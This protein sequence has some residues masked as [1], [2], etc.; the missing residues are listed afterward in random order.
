LFS[1]KKQSVIITDYK[2]KHSPF[3]PNTNYLY[4]LQ[5]LANELT[6]Y[7][8]AHR[9]HSYTLDKVYYCYVYLDPRKPGKY[10]YV[11]PSGK[12]LRFRHKPFYVGKGKSGR[13]DVHLK[14]ASRLNND[15]HKCRIIRK[16]WQA[17]LEPIRLSTDK[18]PVDEAF[19][20]AL[21]IDRIAGIGRKN[22]ANGTNGGD[23]NAGN[24]NH[25]GHKHSK[26][27]LLKMSKAKL[28][29]KRAP[30]TE[31]TRAKMR[32]AFGNKPKSSAHRIAISIAQQNIP[33]ITCPYCGKSGRPAN[34]GRWHFDKCKFRY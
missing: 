34:L 26:Q 1:S 13:I 14:E 5:E 17:G 16:I 2:T 22:L 19:A 11:C 6:E 4:N 9:N 15:N 3:T 25:L 21:E 20:F 12:V 31:T 30:F 33:H 23:G 28:G 24:Q 32:L 27:A 10:Q 18:Q 29:I 7:S 8:F